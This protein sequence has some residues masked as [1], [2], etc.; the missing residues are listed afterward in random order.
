MD[1]LRR[2]GIHP[3]KPGEINWLAV[4]DGDRQE[5]LYEPSRDEIAQLCTKY[6][7]DLEQTMAIL[8]TRA[9]ETQGFLFEAEKWRESC[10]KNE[11]KIDFATAHMNALNKV[12]PVCGCRRTFY[13]GPGQQMHAK[14]VWE[15]WGE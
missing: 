11:E 3:W 12:C 8:D 15:D 10:R 2:M 7:F 6:D 1:S 14:R 5:M 9:P 13:C 4:H